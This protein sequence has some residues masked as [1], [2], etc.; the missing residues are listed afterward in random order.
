M[1]AVASYGDSSKQAIARR[2]EALRAAMSLQIAEERGTPGLQLS[3]AEFARRIGFTVQALNNYLQSVNRI[4][5]DQA[6]GLAL[7]TG[8]TLDWLYLG[9]P[10][11]LPIALSRVTDLEPAPSAPARISRVR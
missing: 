8:I 9:N 1:L 10:A 2:L 4:Q 5:L 3:Q 11:G 6:I 7:K